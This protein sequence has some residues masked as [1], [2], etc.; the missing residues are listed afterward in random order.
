MPVYISLLRGIN[1]G[2]HKRVKMDQ[3]RKSFEALGFE[4][5]KTYIQSG[6]VVFRAGKVS[7]VALSKK[8]E[9]KI[10]GHF[11]FSVS[12]ILRTQDEMDRTI[13]SNPFLKESGID[14]AKLH[15]TFLSE[16]PAP[17]ALR[18]FEAL[19]AAPDKSRYAGTEI[20]FYLPNGM[21]QSSLWKTSW[22]RVLS[23]V[24]TTR[25]WKTVNSLY[26][27]CLDCR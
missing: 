3:L 1:V 27:L 21:S 20:Y 26:Q 8:I 19:I 12:V 6:N 14:Q 9:A 7:P 11:G 5:V 4:Q 17:A 23:V 16:A 18:K 25:N 13:Q 2:G 22:E 24:N 10:L 15:V